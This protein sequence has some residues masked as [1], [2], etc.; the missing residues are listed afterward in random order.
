MPM[1]LPWFYDNTAVDYAAL[2]TLVEVAQAA[3][4]ALEGTARTRLRCGATNLARCAG[5]F[6]EDL[7]AQLERSTRRDEELA[8]RC[9]RLA[10]LADQASQE[11]WADELHRDAL[12]GD[13]EAALLVQA[14]VDALRVAASV[15]VGT[16]PPAVTG[17]GA[18]P[19]P[20]ANPGQMGLP[21]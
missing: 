6:A 20:L 9:R 5:P 21:A 17:S 14:G 7:A 18:S 3:G 2:H 13:H 1:P 11:A 8:Q 15:L 4:T 10:Q 12:R 19:A 16:A